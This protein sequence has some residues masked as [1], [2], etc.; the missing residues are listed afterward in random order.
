[1]WLICLCHLLT[2]AIPVEDH[3]ENN[4]ED[5]TGLQHISSNRRW[6][7]KQ[8]LEC[9]QNIIGWNVMHE[10]F[11]EEPRD[12]WKR[13]LLVTISK[14]RKRGDP[15]QTSQ[16]AKNSEAFCACGI[17]SSIWGN[18]NMEIWIFINTNIIFNL[19]KY[20]YGNTNINTNII[21]NLRNKAMVL[22]MKYTDDL[23]KGRKWMKRICTKIQTKML[24]Q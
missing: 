22:D 14:Q 11:P 13:S 15:Y 23:S 4:Q 16:H 7:L 8:C 21:F 24:N 19:R 5:E 1:M 12:V 9:T 17:W 18:I 20:R 6:Q 3:E 10:S 2:D